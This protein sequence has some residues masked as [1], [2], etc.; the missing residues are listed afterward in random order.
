MS[1]PCKIELWEQDINNLT[2][3]NRAFDTFGQRTNFL[4]PT[5]DTKQTGQF[6]M[7]TKNKTAENIAYSSTDIR[8]INTENTLFYRNDPKVRDTLTLTDAQNLNNNQRISEQQL[9]RT[10]HA[11][12]INSVCYPNID[13]ECWNN[14]TKALYTTVDHRNHSLN[15]LNN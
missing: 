8:N 12:E 14:T 1:S 5:N 2:L 7:D 4:F 15:Y 11:S 3:N 6:N 13:H 9:Y 10:Y